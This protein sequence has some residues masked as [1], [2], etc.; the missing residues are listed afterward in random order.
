MAPDPH[1]I[2]GTSLA[3]GQWQHLRAWAGSA[4]VPPLLLSGSNDLNLG[5]VADELAQAMVCEANAQAAS[6][7]PRCGKCRAC[8]LTRAGNHPDVLHLTTTNATW[9]IK[10]M[11]QI[12]R[13]VVLTASGHRR[14]VIIEAIEKVSVPAAN[15]L[16][17]SLEEPR[18]S[19]SFILTTRWPSR[20]LPTI[21]SRCA[22]IHLRPAVPPPVA[23]R[24]SLDL[25]KL[26]VEGLTPETLE[27]LATRLHLSLR[28]RGSTPALR[29][30]YARLRD[31]HFVVSRH[32]NS[33]LAGEVLLLSLPSDNGMS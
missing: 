1:E 27:M 28:Q 15:A 24:E 32:G 29:R 5:T 8:R 30:A 10:D 16:L 17:K 11:R 23:P 20:L 3:G 33:K 7:Q 31:Y 21:L 22:R 12:T 6:L 13:A 2:G 25:E 18:S 19:T 9:T 14:V 26:T 4:V